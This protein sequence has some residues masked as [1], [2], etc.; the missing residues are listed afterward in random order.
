MKIVKKSRCPHNSV[1]LRRSSGGN[2]KAR[3]MRRQCYTSKMAGDFDLSSGSRA[4]FRSKKL[5][6]F[7]C[8]SDMT[9]VAGYCLK[10]KRTQGRGCRRSKPRSE[11]IHSFLHIFGLTKSASTNFVFLLSQKTNACIPSATRTKSKAYPSLKT[12]ARHRKKTT[13]SRL[14]TSSTGQD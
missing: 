11:T 5:N 8:A 12:S 3:R 4:C 6:C 9:R 10:Q 7:H 2:C 13:L 14:W 1:I